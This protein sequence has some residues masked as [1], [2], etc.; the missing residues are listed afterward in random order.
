MI[1]DCENLVKDYID[2]LRQRISIESVNGV[3]EITTPFLDRHND[4]L[5]IYV[6]KTDNSLILTDDG[7]T[8]NDLKSSGCDLSSQT[9]K[10]KLQTI[11]NGFGVRFS[12]DEIFVETRPENF[13]QK[14]HNL[15]QA[16]LSIN[17]LFFTAAPF[18]ASMFNED[19][20]TY[21]RLNEVRFTPRVKFTGKSGFDHFFD[22]VI[23]ASNKMP[24]RIL[25]A[26][27]KP[28]DKNIKLLIFSWSD[29][30][31]VRAIDSLAYGVLNDSEKDINPSLYSALK[32]Y[33]I[34]PILW[35]QRDKVIN[36][37]AA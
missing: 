4:Q 32:Q 6:K 18:V 9:R 11:I 26:I 7:Y 36:E 3:C 28:D 24:E 5:Q 23:P 19:V 14:K 12:D 27:N 8:I 29:T 37:L 2:W 17:D 16:I 10:R 31:E 35:S 21:L 30:K 34:K 22:F 25:K 20:E 15:I 33:G 13:P 1:Q